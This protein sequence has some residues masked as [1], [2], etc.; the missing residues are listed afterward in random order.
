MPKT[1]YFSIYCILCGEDKESWPCSIAWDC[2]HRPLS[3][4]KARAPEALEN[5]RTY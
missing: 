3:T 2:E 5:Q 4:S 1:D